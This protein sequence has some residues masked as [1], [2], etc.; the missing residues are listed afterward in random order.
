MEEQAEPA[1]LIDHID[2]SG[3]VKARRD[4]AVAGEPANSA[5][6]SYSKGTIVVSGIGSGRQIHNVDLEKVARF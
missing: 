1:H 2:G 5:V 3:L 6:N 4:V